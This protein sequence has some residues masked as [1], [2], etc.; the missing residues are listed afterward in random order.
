MKTFKFS[1]LFDFQKKSKIK[2]GEGLSKAPFPFFTS[3]NVL[4]KYYS[5]SQFNQNSLIFGTGGRASV[6]ICEIPFSVSTDCLVAQLKPGINKKAELKFIYYYLLGNIWI[7]ERGFRGAGLKH[8]S[9]AYIN[10]I[11]VPLPLRV[12]QKRIVKTLDKAYGVSQKRKQAIKLLDEYLK[13]VFIELIRQSPGDNDQ[14][15]ICRLED[16]AKKEKGSM[17]TGPFGSDLKHS[18]FVD[19]G[20][21]VIGIDNAVQNKFAW[22]QRRYITP[23]KYK[24]LK[25]YTLYPNDIIVTIMGT[26]GRSAVIPNDI[27]LAI[28]TK[29]LVAITL[30]KTLANSYFIS[31]SIHSDPSVID[32][33]NR[34]GRG[35]IMT[36]LNLGLVKA[37][38][39]KLPPIALQNEFAE[40]HFR[41]E[42]LKQKMLNQSQ[43][44]DI[45]FQAIMQRAF[46]GKL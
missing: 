5:H 41:Q 3:S 26:T 30:D 34:S 10:N 39:F 37:L 14:W 45:Q 13:S 23:E 43:E 7:L 11:D 9:K 25:R 8:I 19:K 31:Y 16:L 42:K 12:E 27:P 44:L 17:R 4:S 2:A 18:E 6:H 40:I 1:Q 20:I 28:N 24:K 33:L 22:A 32:Q 15:K 46:E 21:A 36:G 29:H 38:Q 35:A